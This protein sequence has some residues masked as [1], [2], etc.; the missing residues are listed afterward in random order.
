MLKHIEIRIESCATGI[1]HAGR[2]HPEG[3]ATTNSAEVGKKLNT[4]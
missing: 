1:L 3:K 4:S 2:E